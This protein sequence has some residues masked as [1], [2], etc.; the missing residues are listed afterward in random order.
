MLSPSPAVILNPSLSVILNE[1]KDLPRPLR[2]GSVKDRLC[3]LRV[4]SAKHLFFR[5]PHRSAKPAP[6][7]GH[8][9]SPKR[10]DCPRPGFASARNLGLSPSGVSARAPRHNAQD[11]ATSATERRDET[12]PTSL[13]TSA[14]STAPEGAF[15]T[16]PNTAS[17]SRATT[18]PEPASTTRPNPASATTSTIRADSGPDSASATRA[19][20]GPTSDLG[21]HSPLQI[22]NANSSPVLH[23]PQ[24]LTPFRPRFSIRT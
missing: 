22:R 20:T 11:C 5:S 10:G 6:A 15:S 3:L 23:N 8:D 16:A 17:E 2:A 19:Q 21:S 13:T 18:A 7:W 24:S 4:D 14:S 1:V 9:R 12:R